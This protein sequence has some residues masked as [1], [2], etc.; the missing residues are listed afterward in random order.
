MCAQG[1]GKDGVGAAEGGA[2]PSVEQ[3]RGAPDG[4]PDTTFILRITQLLDDH[5]ECSIVERTTWSPRRCS[6]SAQPSAGRLGGCGARTL[7]CAAFPGIQGPTQLWR[8]CCLPSGGGWALSPLQV[9]V[10][11]QGTGLGPGK[12]SCLQALGSSIR[13]PGHH[14][15]TGSQPRPDAKWGP[16]KPHCWVPAFCPGLRADHPAVTRGLHWSWLRLWGMKPP[17]LAEGVKAR[18]AEPSAPVAATPVVVDPAR[19]KTKG[20]C[21]AQS[22]RVTSQI[23]ETRK[24]RPFPSQGSEQRLLMVRDRR[25]G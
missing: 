15:E 22:N 25:M 17:S 6:R 3:L 1:A 18:L 4:P 9:T 23:S 7:G 5:L 8:N 11:A 12:T 24:Q 20:G 14:H 19:V 13:I 10:P 2:L 21:G 16:T